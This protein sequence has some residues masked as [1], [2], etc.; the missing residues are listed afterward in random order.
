MI[1]NELQRASQLVLG[2]EF[3]PALQV[4]TQ[5]L[6]SEP[7]SI[8]GKALMADVQ[9]G[10]GGPG[11]ALEYLAGMTDEQAREPELL[12]RVALYQAGSNNF[13]QAA[14]TYQQYLEGTPEDAKRWLEYGQVL[15]ALRRYQESAQACA[16]AIEH[17]PLSADGYLKLG[18]LLQQFGSYPQAVSVY[19]QGL[20]QIPGDARLQGDMAAAY[21]DSGDI[22]KA[23]EAFRQAL[24]A[25]PE[26]ALTHYNLATMKLETGELADARTHLRS[27][28]R[29]EPRFAHAYQQ[30]VYLDD[31]EGTESD[32]TLA[33]MESLAQDANM[34]ADGRARILFGLAH[35]QEKRGDYRKAMRACKKANGL[36]S[37]QRPFN[38]Q[39]YDKVIK[40][41]TRVFSAS[42][43]K[44]FPA[45]TAER[46]RPVV[47]AGMPRT[48]T[49]LIDQMLSGHP[50]VASLGEN[51]FMTKVK[52]ESVRRFQNRF[53]YPDSVQ[54][55]SPIDLMAL[56]D[57]WY[58]QARATAP[59][60]SYVVDK[61]LTNYLNVGLFKLLFPDCVIVE[62]TREWKDVALSMFF[63]DFADGHEYAFSRDGLNFFRDGYNELMSHWR[64]LDTS[65]WIPVAYEQL[66]QHPHETLAPIFAALELT[67]HAD[68]DSF[69]RRSNQ[70]RTLSQTQVR[71]P[72]NSQSVGKHQRY[73]DYWG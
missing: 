27:A 35:L 9:A 54:N 70:V 4:L 34:P 52:G 36:R 37:Q 64:S 53:G 3:G 38:A 47:I 19:Q 1:E 29:I 28:V 6:E 41:H 18:E 14:S 15:A 62:A 72:L 69:Y 46:P 23:E 43:L 65:P 11:K 22:Q 20:L 63:A 59:G 60:A 67:P 26:N 30:L 55:C 8:R 24:L 50:D 31:G 2:G 25:D 45:M 56:R 33:R 44:R 17:A 12:A 61:T 58:Q 42:L 51:D 57:L 49:T 40:R 5:V 21:K 10:L 32:E 66:V 16:K 68:L 48:G 7:G 73:A 71:N 13:D 39:Q